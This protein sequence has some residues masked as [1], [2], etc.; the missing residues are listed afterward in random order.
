MFRTFPANRFAASK[1]P[2]LFATKCCPIQYCH[3]QQIQNNRSK[4]IASDIESECIDSEIE[5]GAEECSDLNNMAMEEFMDLS[6]LCDFPTVDVMMYDKPSENE[7][8]LQIEHINKEHNYCRRTFCTNFRSTSYTNRR[9]VSQ[10]RKTIYNLRKEVKSIR[11]EASKQ[12]KPFANFNALPTFVKQFFSV[13]LKH[14]NTGRPKKYT[15]EIR[16]FALTLH[17]YSPTS[18]NYV[19]DKFMSCLPCDQSIRNWYRTV[20]GTPG[21]S[22]TA[23]GALQTLQQHTPYQIVGCVSV[24][25]MHLRK[26]L[27]SNGNS[28]TGYVDFGGV[29]ET[30]KRQLA[31]EALNIMFVASLA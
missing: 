21:F 5:F 14:F 15:P 22:N 4:L 18:Y 23:L 25:G 17:Y 12:F 31:N 19:R 20:D 24:D 30:D 11:K 28:T 8:E 10:L 13:V 3:A 16:Q 29:I 26:H 7:I 1:M 2:K 6:T 9:K 27:Q